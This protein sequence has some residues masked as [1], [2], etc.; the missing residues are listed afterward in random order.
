MAA[1]PSPIARLSSSLRDRGVTPPSINTYRQAM[2]AFCQWLHEEGH[3]P[4]LVKVRLLRKEKRV[5]VTV[6]A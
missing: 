3:A 5:L 4:Q 6:R 1:S 2:N